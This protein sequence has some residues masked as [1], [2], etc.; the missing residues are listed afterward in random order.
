MR[1][2]FSILKQ[3]FLE[4]KFRKLRLCTFAGVVLA[5]GGQGK[6]N[7]NH[8]WQRVID[9]LEV[10]RLRRRIL[11]MRRKGGRGKLLKLQEVANGEHGVMVG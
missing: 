6:P 8:Q 10:D 5:S 9:N 2:H 11:L 7:I 1:P 3:H 4:Y